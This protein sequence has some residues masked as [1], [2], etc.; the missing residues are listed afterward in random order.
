MTMPNDFAN[1][2]ARVNQLQADHFVDMST[3]VLFFEVVFANAQEG[4]VASCRFMVE[5]FSAGAIRP[6]YE[7]FVMKQHY[8]VFATI[9]GVVAVAIFVYL[10]V[11]LVNETLAKEWT[12][13]E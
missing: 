8:D 7:V 5:F 12:S 4:L 6:S 1:A 13:K 2:T 11:E 3:R 9:T 10:L